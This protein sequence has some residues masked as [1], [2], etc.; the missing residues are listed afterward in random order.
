[1]RRLIRLHSSGVQSMGGDEGSDQNLDLPLCWISQHG[2]L[3][4]VFMHKYQNIMC[5]HIYFIKSGLI[6]AHIKGNGQCQLNSTQ[7]YLQIT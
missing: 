3:I 2:P 6:N 7:I 4:E 1:M 5:W